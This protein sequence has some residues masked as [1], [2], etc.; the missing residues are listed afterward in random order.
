MIGAPAVTGA[1]VKATGPGLSAGLPGSTLSKGLQSLYSGTIAGVDLYRS[2][3]LAKDAND[4]VVG[5]VFHEMAMVFVP[6]RHEGAGGS[7]FTRESDDGRSVL[8][9]LVEDYGFGIL[10]G[11]LGVGVTLD[12]T[13][14]TS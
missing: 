4:D 11:N 14:P 3:N 12:G 7:I 6:F 5:A 10:D 9:T 8:M 13:P 2:S 1:T